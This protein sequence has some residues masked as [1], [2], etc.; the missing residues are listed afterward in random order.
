M[1]REEIIDQI[2]CIGQ[3]II[4]DAETLK[5]EPSKLTGIT[6]S[7][8]IR[9]CKITEITYEFCRISDTRLLNE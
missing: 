6:I 2:K 5:F 7:A 9:P 8:E 4:D 1:N 3:S